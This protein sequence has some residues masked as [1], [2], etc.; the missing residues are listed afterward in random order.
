MKIIHFAD[1]HLGVE[2]Y[3]RIDPETGMS[4][5]FLDFLCAFD[6]LCDYAIENRADLVLFCGD[7]YKSRDPNPT[8]QRE[9]ARR[10]KRLSE[11]GVPVF[12]LTGNHDMPNAIGR[13]TTI[14]IFNT[15]AVADVC[16]A[17]RPGTHIIDTPHGQIQVVAL[18]WMRRSHLVAKEESQNLTLEQINQLMQQ[19]LSNII[20]AE[21]E[22]LNPSLPAVL[23]AHVWVT[24]ARTGSEEYMTIGREQ[25]LLPGVAANP[26][27]DYVALGHIH[28][29]QVLLEKPPLVYSGSLERLD[30]GDENDQKGFYVVDIAPGE[31]GRDVS[32]RF[33]PLEGRRFLT[34]QAEIQP[35]D[36]DTTTAIVNAVNRQQTA[37]AIVR[38]EISMPQ[39]SEGQLRDSDIRQALGDA[40]YFTISRNVRREN[41][42]RLGGT[43]AEEISPIQALQSYVKSVKLSDEQAKTVLEYGQRLIR[44][45]QE[46]DE[47]ALSAPA[48]AV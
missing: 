30:F 16:I 19:K 24:G 7:A 4:S 39:E 5:R 27:F 34:I 28:R 40:H 15:L 6:K 44:N 18:P 46:G 13:A 32:Y 47:G 17:N 26:T 11:N 33:V 38:L 35:G 8:Q 25:E 21:A 20:A 43:A 22:K 14:E 42:L 31:K 37:G 9:F 29:H 3:G 12:L 45:V 2:T 41:R 10:I 1:L 23:A 48:T 36:A